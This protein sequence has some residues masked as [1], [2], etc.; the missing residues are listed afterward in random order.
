MRVLSIVHERSA[1]MGV[2][3][4]AVAQRGDELLEWV[5]S[6]ADTPQAD[7]F[8]AALLFGGAMHVDQEDEH[9]WLG[10]EKQLL[11]GLLARDI[12][13]L[14]V[15]LGAQLLAEVA[16]GAAKRAA[17]PEI[18][19]KTVQLDRQAARDALLGP[20][21][22]RFETFQWHSY[23]LSVPLGAVELARS[24]ACL[25]AFRLQGAGGWGIQFHAEAT[26][27]TIVEWVRDYRSD[28]DAVRADLDWNSMLAQTHSEITRSN[29]LGMGLCRRFLE[30]AATTGALQLTKRAER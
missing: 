16:G 24:A 19:W 20:L 18:G 3:A 12:P 25:Q 21:P 15:C 4:D 22:A 5:P 27:E 1:G 29:E 13:V 26:A 11:R 2:F 28:E 23:E 7:G 30:H 8:G 6:E 14:G 9:R 10:G 17:E